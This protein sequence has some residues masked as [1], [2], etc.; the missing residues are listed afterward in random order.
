MKAGPLC[1]S[2]KENQMGS[3]EENGKDQKFVQ[4]T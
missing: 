3:P 1:F 4:Q 2:L